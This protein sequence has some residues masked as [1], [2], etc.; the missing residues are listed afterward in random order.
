MD[1]F[2]TDFNN[3]EKQ[4]NL[5]VTSLDEIKAIK[6]K[7]PNGSVISQEYKMKQASL[8]MRNFVNDLEVLANEYQNSGSKF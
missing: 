6:Q 4:V 7:N 2:Q 8:N 5:I 1:S 3:A